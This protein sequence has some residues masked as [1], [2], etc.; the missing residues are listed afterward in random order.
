[1]DKESLI[2]LTIPIMSPVNDDKEK[3]QAQQRERCEQP[4]PRGVAVL[5]DGEWE[6]QSNETLSNLQ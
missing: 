4:N 3:P 1:M 6:E 2:E 5:E